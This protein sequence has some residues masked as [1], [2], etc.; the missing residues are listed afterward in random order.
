MLLPRLLVLLLDEL[1]LLEEAGRRSIHGTA[2]CLPLLEERLVLPE[3][4]LNPE[5][6]PEDEPLGL[7][8]APE[9]SPL[10]LPEDPELNPL[11]L[12]EPELWPLDPL[13]EP[14]PDEEPLGVL[15]LPVLLPLE[16][17]DRIAKSILPEVGLMIVSLMVPR[18]SPEEPVTLPP[19]SWLARKS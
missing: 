14:V 5:L 16:F 2:T 15:P 17:S 19:M 6:L 12:L 8:L 11:E 18:V 10:A 13:E 1:A 3:L 9:L 7:L 4:L